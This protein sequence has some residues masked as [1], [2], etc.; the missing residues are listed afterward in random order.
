MKMTKKLNPLT[1]DYLCMIDEVPI[2]AYYVRGEKTAQK[3]CDNVNRAISE[4]ILTKEILEMSFDT[5]EERD[6]W[7]AEHFP[8][9]K[10]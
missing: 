3:F 1:G 2:Q 9:S 5:E 7:Q 8:K 6:A 10:R 4:G